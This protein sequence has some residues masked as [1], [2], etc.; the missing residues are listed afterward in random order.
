MKRIAILL[1]SLLLS[2]LSN[3][4][5]DWENPNLPAEERAKILVSSLTL[6][7][8]VGLIMAESKEVERVGLP[9]YAWSHEALHGLA[10]A[11]KA[12]VFPQA[13][14]LAAT[15]DSSL[16]YEM[17]TAISDEARAKY[18]AFKR[19]NYTGPF[20]GLTFYSPNINIYRDPRWGRGMETY[21]E[22]PYLTSRI[23]L[24]Y[25]HGM[26]GNNPK[27]LKTATC[28]KHFAVHSGPEKDRQ[29]I[30]PKPSLKDLNETYLPHFKSLIQ[31]GNVEMVMVAYNKLYDIP[32]NAS[33]FA[34]RELLRKKL[35]FKGL[36]ITDGGALDHIHKSQ[37]YTKNQLETAA[38]ALKAG[39]NLELGNQLEVLPQAIKEGLLSEK[40]IDSSAILAMTIRFKLGLLDPIELNP[41]NTISEDVINCEKH[42]KLARKI[43]AKSI[44]LLKNNGA[45]P[46]KKD[47]RKLYV[48][49]PNATNGDVLF[50]NYNGFTGNMSIPLEGLVNNIQA[51]TILEY[52]PGSR[53]DQ[54]KLTKADWTDVS[55]QFDAIVAYMGLSPLLEGEEGE[56]IS[57]PGEG[58]RIKL[59]LPPN[60]VEYLKKQRSY[61]TKPIILVLF[62]GSPIIDKEIYELAD[63]V[64][65]CWYPGEEGGNA[66]ADIIF[67]DVN[68]SGRLPIT[69][70]M[71]ENDLPDFGDYAMKDRT[72]RFI[73][74]EPL[75]PFGFGLSYTKFELKNPVVSKNLINKKE[76]FNL[77]CSI[78][79]TGNFDG[80]ETVQLYI[81]LPDAAQN[82]PNH[83]LKSIKKVFLKKGESKTITFAINPSV[84]SSFNQKGEE[85]IVSGKYKLIIAGA[86]PHPKSVQLGATIPKEIEF[87]VK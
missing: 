87:S 29:L 34:S 61:G 63:A 35:K 81:T 83:S 43:A 84:Y 15:F 56:A 48:V 74:K 85:I 57:S 18:L 4:Q 66:I 72:Y 42:R 5:K 51:N 58:D 13:I 32:L 62:G 38:M 21:G 2:Q 19:V 59:N 73:S 47:I 79:N 53:L 76:T 67:G 16:V 24:A 64:L 68:P 20:S 44:V 50:G 30:N 80:E 86:S 10:R 23:G 49:G 11:G 46:L 69:F 27:H 75:F 17:A 55:H 6:E 7:E 78:T 39:I 33:V 31:E 45:L 77:T 9:A 14:G 12:T 65:Y 70:P 41:Y 60:Q 28:A 52:R 36:I 8:K 25:V 22:D 40:T 54:D 1:L 37:A 71:S 26:Q 3:A 82:K